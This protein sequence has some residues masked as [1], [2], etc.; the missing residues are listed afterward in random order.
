MYCIPGLH[1][2]PEVGFCD[3]PEHFVC[4]LTSQENNVDSSSEEEIRGNTNGAKLLNE[5]QNN[6]FQNP[7]SAPKPEI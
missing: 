4:D 6:F 2:N 5:F 3:F 7:S 1:F